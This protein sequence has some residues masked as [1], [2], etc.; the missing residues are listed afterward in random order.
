[1]L[2]DLQWESQYELQEQGHSRDLY[3][4]KQKHDVDPWP[5]WSE[6]Q[7]G[8]PAPKGEEY[9]VKQLRWA[10][11]ESHGDTLGLGLGKIYRLEREFLTEW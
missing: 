11:K 8:G 4:C 3:D 10:D 5:S 2:H 6:V 7:K 1:M 9:G